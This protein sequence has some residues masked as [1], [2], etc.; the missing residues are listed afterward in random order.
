[1]HRSVI[2]LIIVV[3]GLLHTRS[4]HG[5]NITINNDLTF[6]DVFPG[7][8]KTIS[9]YTP[10]AAAEFLITGTAGAEVSLDF[11]LPTYMND[12]GYNMQL[13]FRE[14]DCAMDSSASPDQTDPGHDNQD[15]WHTMTYRLG[16]SGLT[17]WLGGMVVPKL[18]QGQ[19]NYSGTIVLTVMYTGN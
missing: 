2:I 16:S 8:P 7:I 15:P 14:T 19:G 9:K 18:K 10:G 13:V 3:L 4:A 12:G 17:I 6:G 5:Q 1:M 11:T